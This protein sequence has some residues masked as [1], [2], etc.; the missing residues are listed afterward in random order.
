MTAEANITPSVDPVPAGPEAAQPRRGR[1][2]RS[3][4]PQS[5][6]TP[7]AN[8]ATGMPVHTHTGV[9]AVCVKECFIDGLYR[10]GDRKAFPSRESVSPHFRIIE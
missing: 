9:T 7:E 10:P 3:E 6:A 8:A 5:D 2:P 1:K 4:A